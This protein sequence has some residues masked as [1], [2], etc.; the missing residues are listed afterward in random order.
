[1]AMPE[2]LPYTEYSQLHRPPLFDGISR[3][4]F[5]SENQKK[6]AAFNRWLGSLHLINGSTELTAQPNLV[7]GEEPDWDDARRV[8]QHKVETLVDQL[9]G[10]DGGPAL[11]VG[12]DVV[13]WLQGKPLLNLS[14]KRDL[15]GS[16]LAAS[17][18]HLQEIFS[19]PSEARWD[20]AFS[21]SRGVG[22]SVIK[23]TIM[24]VITV[25]YGPI[26]PALIHEI[27]FEDI[28]RALGINTKIPLIDDPRFQSSIRS[29]GITSGISLWDRSSQALIDAGCIQ[30]CGMDWE[31]GQDEFP[32]IRDVAVGEITG[33]LPRNRRMDQLLNL[34]PHSGGN[35]E[36]KLI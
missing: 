25:S 26:D 7:I 21:L 35:R 31:S 23:A 6:L 14:R 36:W 30:S 24:D 22:R 33:G 28:P 10:K 18:A 1:M 13:F 8:S 27:F 32:I 29:I 19:K 11:V 16:D 3:V 17:V 5:A 9:R 20:V 12:S 15:S 2:A 4:M 34:R